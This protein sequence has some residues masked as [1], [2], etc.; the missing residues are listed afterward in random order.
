MKKYEIVITDTSVFIN[1]KCHS[2]DHEMDIENK[3]D[4]LNKKT[5]LALANEMGY[6]PQFL[7]EEMAD[8]LEEMLYEVDATEQ[9][10]II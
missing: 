1:G 8:R 3:K 6:E 2:F 7:F 4:D 5:L 9:I 10:K